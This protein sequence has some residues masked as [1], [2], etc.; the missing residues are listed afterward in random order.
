MM[1][2]TNL[3]FRGCT[4]IMLAVVLAMFTLQMSGQTL[5]GT[6]INSWI[7]NSN[8]DDQTFMPQGIEGMYVATDGTVYTN[9]YWE[10]GGGQQTEVK[11]GVVKH[12]WG[13][14]GWGHQGGTAITANANYVYYSQEYGSEGGGLVDAN[15]WP[16][17]GIRWVGISRRNKSD[18]TTGTP[19]TGGKGGHAG[20]PTG[21]FLPVFELPEPSGD[22]D[23]GIRGLA[24]TAT[25]LFASCPYDNKIRVFDANTMALKRSFTVTNPYHLALDNQGKIWISIGYNATKI[26]CYDA[27]GVKQSQELT[28]LDGS[29]VGSIAIDSNNRL[30]VGDV[31]QNE[32][33]LIYTNIDT[34]PAQTST[35]GTKFGIY[36]GVPGQVAPLKFHQVRGVGV[37]NAGNFYIGN[38][39]WYTNG[40][41]LILESYTSGGSLS[42]SRNCVLFVDAASADKNTDGADIYGPVEHFSVDYSKPAGQEATLVGYTVNRYKYPKDPRLSTY[43]STSYVKTLNGKKF[44]LMFGQNSSSPIC[45]FRFNAATDGE[46]AI[47]CVIWDGGTERIYPNAPNGNWMWR[48]LNANGQMDAGEYTSTEAGSGGSSAAMDS[49]GDIWLAAGDLKKIAY[50]GLDANGIPMFDGTFTTIAKPAPFT[51]IRRVRYYPQTDEMYLGGK[52]TDYPDITHWKPMGRKLC[53]YNNWSTG[54][55]TA[56]FQIVVPFDATKIEC[57]TASFDVAGD[58][59]FTAIAQGNGGAY[60]M[61]QINVYNALTGASVGNIRPP[62]GNIGWMDMVEPLIV[63]QRANGEY[64]ILQEEDGRNKNIMYRWCATGNCSQATGVVTGVT[65]SPTTALIPVSATSQLTATVAPSNATNK[66]VTWTTSNT[67]IA[68]VSSTGLVTGVASGNATITVTTADGSKTATCA[69]TV[70]PLP[71]GLSGNVTAEFWTGIS[72]TTIPAIPTTVANT[73]STLTSLEIPV[74]ALDNYLVRITGY[75]VPSTTGSYNLYIASDD[76]GELWLSINDL[77]S[78][79]LRIAYHT[80]FTDSRQW[81][82]FATQKSANISLTAGTKYYFETLVKEGA[83][84]DNLAI[85]WTG[86]G[87]SAITVI[88]STNLDKYVAVDNIP[89]TSVSISPTTVSVFENATTQLTATVAPSNATNKNVI[90]SSSNAAIANV[91]TSGLF[92]GIAAGTAS[93]TVTTADG[94]KTATCAVTVTSAPTGITGDVTA[95]FWTG[96]SGT[97]IPAIP[98]SAPNSTSTISSVEIPSDAMDNYLVRIRGYIVPSTTGTYNLYIAS[99]DN[100]QLWLSTNSDPANKAQIATV[101]D[102]TASREWTKYATQKSANK[103]LTANTKYYFE[104]IMKEGGG[105]DNLAIGWTGPGIS[106]ITVIGS[107]NL[108]KYV[109]SATVPVTG[110]TMNPTTAS[111]AVNATSQLTATVAP[112][113]ATNKNVTWSTSSST[114]ATVSSTGL[115]TGKVAGTATITVTTADGSKTATCA[116]TVTAPSCI[117]EQGTVTCYNAASTMTVDG[118]LN[119]ASWCISNTLTKTAMGTKNNTVTFGV[120]YDNTNLYVGVKVLDANLYANNSTYAWEN[121]G[122]ELYFDPNN[123][124]GTSYDANDRQYIKAKS[125]L[126]FWANAGGVSGASVSWV[127]ITGGYTMEFKIPFTLLGISSTPAN[128][129]IIGFDIANDDDD[130]GTGRTIQSIWNGDGTDYTNPSVFGDLKISS[131]LKSA[132]Y[133]TEVALEEQYSIMVY[134]N[135]VTNVLHIANAAN[136][137]DISIFSMDGKLVSKLKANGAEMEIDVTSWNKGIYIFKIN[138]INQNMATKLIIKQLLGFKYQGKKLI[139]QQLVRRKG[140]NADR[141]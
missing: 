118:Y 93:I 17:A 134:P 40:Q 61:G 76:N 73:S 141:G 24:A 10:E 81:T 79:K 88:G 53:K 68:T 65:M 37:D 111:I 5:P 116:V 44:L 9:V 21:C 108:D 3:K 70:T 127:N 64:V 103:S 129:T 137:A 43:C 13:S 112:S 46:V 22:W 132:A 98:A 69:V 83:G 32:Q 95:E 66:S 89:P 42:W 91:S 33:V 80:D 47:P 57:E 140:Q 4:Q 51:E 60:V 82:K 30:I 122:I 18:I 14:H 87:I 2:Y 26:E 135:P 23:A 39:Q 121:D 84:G 74:N 131:T 58:Y 120:L 12:A 56:A 110:V 86:P 114:V 123:S 31:G 72:G 119:E 133:E 128:N 55:R 125:T 45:I 49:N 54:N 107:T 102:W 130:A 117:D 59:I 101:G 62:W 136:N 105:G 34:A 35:F 6:I 78:N 124:G 48:D 8:A 38:T 15:H 106:T 96:L 36:S 25:E 90:W 29:F 104:A 126:A 97:T 7:G 113:N 115:V 92:T 27:N 41:G 11:N 1:K 94:G 19:F 75:I 85:G 71:S 28:M 16:P 63:I 52:T 139:I 20:A 77:P 109:A 100:G 138:S 99:D 50:K 67:A